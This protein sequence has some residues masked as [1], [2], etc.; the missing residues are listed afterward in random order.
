MT[1]RSITCLRSVPPGRPS[2]QKVSPTPKPIPI[3]EQTRAKRTAWSLKKSIGGPPSRSAP[4]HPG[5]AVFYH[6]RL[7]ACPAEGC[8]AEMLFGLRRD[9]RDDRE[10]KL[11]QAF[12]VRLEDLD[13][14][15]VA[16]RR[17]AVDADVVV[18]DHDDVR[19][20]EPDLAAE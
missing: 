19:V 4:R 2:T 6:R 15:L 20:A 1:A 8:G 12:I 18:G 5:A 11:A 14:R 7:D 9:L 16:H 17:R 3:A 13:H 10:E